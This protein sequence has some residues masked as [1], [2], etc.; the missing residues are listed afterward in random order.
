MPLLKNLFGAACGAA[1][2]LALTPTFAQTTEPAKPAAKPAAKPPSIVMPAAKPAAKSSAKGDAK[3]LGGKGSASGKLL[4]RDELRQCMARLDAFNQGGKDLEQ[5]RATL[6]RERLDIAKAGEDLKVEREEID[7]K[8]ALVD[9]W[10][11]RVRVQAQEVDAF[12]KKSSAADELSRSQREAAVKELEADRVRLSAAR[13]ALAAEEA[14]VVTTY[15]DGA[16]AYNARAEARDA[17]VGDWNKR[18]AAL[19]EAALKRDEERTGWLTECA[20]RPYREDDEIA[21]K[22]GK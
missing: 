11:G 5:Q 17:R 21:I 15:Q 19:N 16:K 1:L 8:R 9:A 14:K 18:N 2:A 7:R 13:D 10:Q 12:N 20:N 3:T 4:T 22:K 6:D